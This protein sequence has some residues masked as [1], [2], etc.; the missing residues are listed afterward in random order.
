MVKAHFMRS[1]KSQHFGMVLYQYCAGLLLIF[2][3]EIK[4]QGFQLIL[5]CL[6]VKT[7][8]ILRLK[9]RLIESKHVV[10]QN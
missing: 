9:R 1:V 8:R 2:M 10:L 7:I 4:M 6:L 3:Y 5:K